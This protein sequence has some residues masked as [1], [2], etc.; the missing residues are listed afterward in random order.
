L[1]QV[2]I[3]VFRL[4]I[5]SV[6]LIFSTQNCNL[7]SGSTL[8]PPPPFPVLKYSIYRQFVAER[9]WGVLIPVGDQFCRSLKLCIWPDLEPTNCWT[10][11]N[12]TLGEE[13]FDIAFY[14]YNLSTV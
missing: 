14:Q 5:Q 13:T 2:F 12:K 4:E 10:N 1:R 11:P 6:M 7:L 9:G 8:N 3:R